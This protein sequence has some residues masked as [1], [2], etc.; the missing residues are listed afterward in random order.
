MKLIIGT[1]Q[2]GMRYGVAGG[3]DFD[4]R[5]VDDLLKL[6]VSHNINS[7]DTAPGYGDAHLKIGKSA[8]KNL[9]IITK[10][11]K[12]N[13]KTNHYKKIKNDVKNYLTTLN[14]RKLYC[15]LL[16]NPKDFLSSNGNSIYLALNLLKEE[17]LIEKFGVS[18]YELEDLN[19]IVDNFKIDIVQHPVNILDRRLEKSGTLKKLNIQGIEVHCR[20]VFLQ[21]LLLLNLER[22]NSKFYPFRKDL[23]KIHNFSMKSQKTIQEICLSYVLNIKNISKIIVGIDDKKQLKEL[24]KIIE[25]KEVINI[26]EF[27]ISNKNILDP[28]T[29]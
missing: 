3:G 24:I 12:L 5:K 15:L 7:I 10:L 29:W 13:L 6:A 11:P 28:R 21:G 4:Q 26:P 22:I 1:A 14:C 18:T 9:N 2:I 19:S 17:G 23:L 20:S 16:H 8:V 27:K 25:N